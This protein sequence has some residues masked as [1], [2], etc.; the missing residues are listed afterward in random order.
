[1][2]LIS[3]TW[4]ILSRSIGFGEAIHNYV[5]AGSLEGQGE[6]AGFWF[7]ALV[8]FEVRQ[9]LPHEAAGFS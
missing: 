4:Q 2:R 5:R 7:L 8:A 9:Q 1:M 3:Q 6:F